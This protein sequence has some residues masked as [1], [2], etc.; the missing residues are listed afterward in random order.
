MSLSP[1]RLFGTDLRTALVGFFLVSIF[2][3]DVWLGITVPVSMLL[4]PFVFIAFADVNIFKGIPLGFVVLLGMAL[5]IVLQFAAGR[6]LAGK[7]DAV[8]FLPIAYALATMLALRHAEMPAQL[9]WRAL[10]VG[11][12][13]SAAVMTLMMLFVPVGHFLVP[14]QNL[15]ATQHAYQEA[16]KQ[17]EREPVA[18][19]GTA[20]DAG[21]ADDFDYGRV[22][23][24]P[25][26]IEGERTEFEHGFYGF[27]RK[28][29]NALGQS[30]YI[31]V[32]FVFLFAVA[33][34]QARW[35]TAT[36]FALLTMATLSRFGV[37][38]LGLT[39]F[40]WVLYRRGFTRAVLA[41]GILG[42]GLLVMFAAILAA[43]TM[44]LPTS[45][46]NRITY[47]QS[48]IDVIAAHPLV[49]AP[50]SYV[51]DRFGLDILWNPHNVL[52][53]VS[54]LAGIIGLVF[55]VGFLVLALIEIDRRARTSPMWT[56]VFFGFVVL[57][58]WGLFEPVAFTPAFE[59]LLAALY[60]LARNDGA[61]ALAVQQR[62]EPAPGLAGL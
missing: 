49:G 37:G 16:A 38:F 57:L 51:L 5:P 48:A 30:N 17:G 34:F 41:A 45:L 62:H 21:S 28:I 52:L 9:I 58:M 50:R 59:L 29:R 40:L 10:V 3:G 54:S 14:G 32:F 8:V 61:S 25:L 53:W 2:Y 12:G 26:E 60:T 22:T 18:R 46:L 39:L 47:G 13:I 6:P 27:K 31:A 15:Y 56:G 11:G 4:L 36:V 23:K 42:L 55:Y 44:A 33:F 24:A 35:T 19:R 43:G 1:L 7:S 20:S